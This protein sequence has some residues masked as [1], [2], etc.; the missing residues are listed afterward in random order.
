M[1]NLSQL[2]QAIAIPT[3]IVGDLTQAKNLIDAD[4]KYEAKVLI[5]K[6]SNFISLEEGQAR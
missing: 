4:K 2:E 1:N 6:V 5:D 3:A